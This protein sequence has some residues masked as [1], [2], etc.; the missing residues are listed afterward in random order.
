MGRTDV[1]ISMEAMKP[2]VILVVGSGIAYHSSLSA[3]LGLDSF[4]LYI[5]ALLIHGIIL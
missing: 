4:I 5:G 1:A 3:I 2:G